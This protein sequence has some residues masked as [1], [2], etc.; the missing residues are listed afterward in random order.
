MNSP[1]AR[2]AVHYIVCSY[3]DPVL[4]I[5]PGDRIVVET[6][7]AFDGKINTRWGF[8][9][10]SSSPPPQFDERRFERAEPVGAINN[11]FQSEYTEFSLR[12]GPAP[13]Y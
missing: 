4:R 13:N 6:R 2:A 1:S 7:D 8:V 9:R 11:I 3:S 10:R 5:H 12:D